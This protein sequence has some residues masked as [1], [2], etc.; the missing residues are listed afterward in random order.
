M[1]QLTT[2]LSKQTP[3]NIASERSISKYE[4]IWSNMKIHDDKRGYIINAAS[5]IVKYRK[6][7]ELAVMGTKIPWYFIGI[8]YYREEGLKFK[9]HIHNG[10]SLKRRTVNVPAG[11]PLVNPD[12]PIG[13][14]FST[15]AADL[16][17]LKQWH[18]VPVWSIS[19]LL[20]YFEANN[21]FGY[22]RKGINTP[23]LWSFTNQ[24]EKGLYAFILNR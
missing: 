2:I 1:V 11:R 23:Y 13:Y 15:S 7:F 6:Q 19:S 20:Y 16:I 9:G 4:Q 21:G 10:D 8:I 5:N 12:T 24:Y 22:V 18:K 17:Q 3:V 14:S